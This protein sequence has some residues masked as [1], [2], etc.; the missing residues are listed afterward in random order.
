MHHVTARRLG[1][2]T[3]TTSEALLRPGRDSSADYHFIAPTFAAFSTTSQPKHGAVRSGQTSCPYAQLPGRSAIWTATTPVT[4]KPYPVIA[5]LAQ[6]HCLHMV[7]PRLSLLG[8]ELSRDTLL[9]YGP[10]AQPRQR[11]QSMVVN[12][13]HTEVSQWTITSSTELYVETGMPPLLCDFHRDIPC[14]SWSGPRMS[15]ASTYHGNQMHQI[16]TPSLPSGCTCYLGCD[17]YRYSCRQCSSHRLSATLS[18]S[19]N[20]VV[21]RCA[22]RV[23]KPASPITTFRHAQI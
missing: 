9:G 19:D 1:C 16:E 17:L 14:R 12:C 13:L 7:M 10:P 21:S 2:F 5:A 18:S 22:S 6:S 23:N 11:L 20:V 15:R 4:D 8:R 3:I